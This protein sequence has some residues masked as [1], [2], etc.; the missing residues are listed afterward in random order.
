MTMSNRIDFTRL[1]KTLQNLVLL[2]VSRDGNLV[3]K[4]LRRPDRF[5]SDTNNAT[6]N[7][8]VIRPLSDVEQKMFHTMRKEMIVPKQEIVTVTPFIEMQNRKFLHPYMAHVSSLFSPENIISVNRYLTQRQAALL[9]TYGEQIE[10]FQREFLHRCEILKEIAT[11][12]IG[13]DGSALREQADRMMEYKR[14]VEKKAALKK[15]IEAIKAELAFLTLAP[16]EV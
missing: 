15:Q 11:A 8:E 12:S 2:D 7:I 6:W 10:D 9:D 5:Y 14:R 13:L 16:I 3:K 1:P 4:T